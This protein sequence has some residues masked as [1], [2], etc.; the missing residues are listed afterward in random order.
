MK[1]VKT[2]LSF[3]LVTQWSPWRRTCRACPNLLPETRRAARNCLIL[4]FLC[5]LST[6]QDL[7]APEDWNGWL[8]WSSSVPAPLRVCWLRRIQHEP[9]SRKS[10][11]QVRRGVD[12]VDRQWGNYSTGPMNL[13]FDFTAYVHVMLIIWPPSLSE[14]GFHCCAATFLVKNRVARWDPPIS[15]AVNPAWTGRCVRSAPVV[16][17]GDGVQVC[18]PELLW[19][20]AVPTT[21]LFVPRAPAFS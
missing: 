2:A 1:L 10:W 9:Q 11:F 17:C 7:W 12:L 14:N 19:Q 18:L 16:C 8:S 13:R 21:S 3:K 6:Q 5:P 15:T 20:Q 4:C